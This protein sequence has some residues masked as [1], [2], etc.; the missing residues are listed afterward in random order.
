MQCLFSDFPI[1]GL[2][3]SRLSSHTHPLPGTIC[4]SVTLVLGGQAKKGLVDGCARRSQEDVVGG[5][6]SH[7]WHLTAP[8]TL[9][10]E[11]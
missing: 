9:P 8:E 7:K 3:G 11:S 2:E 5:S 6:T 1:L 4:T 10:L